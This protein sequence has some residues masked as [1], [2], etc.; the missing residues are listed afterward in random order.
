MIARITPPITPKN[1][2]STVHIKVPLMKPSITMLWFIASKTKGQLNAGLVSTMC[3]NISTSTAI[4][5][6]AT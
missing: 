4:T 1:I 2:A 5:A 3:R 6:I